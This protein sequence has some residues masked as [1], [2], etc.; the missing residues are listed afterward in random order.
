MSTGE[1]E[2]RFLYRYK[3]ISNVNT[4]TVHVIVYLYI[5]ISK[6]KMKFNVQ[7]IDN[8][9]DLILFA[10]NIQL[11]DEIHWYLHVHAPIQ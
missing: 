4:V 2:D 1:K 9:I 3:L 7:Y 6:A 10:A 8:R 11:L 5:P